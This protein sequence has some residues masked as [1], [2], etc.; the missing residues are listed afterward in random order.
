GQGRTGTKYVNWIPTYNGHEW[1]ILEVTPRAWGSPQSKLAEVVLSE[2]HNERGEPR[3]ELNE[4]ERRRIL[5]WI[6]LNVPYYG[7][8][9]TAY[10]KQRGCRQL[11]PPNLDAVLA[12]VAK[13]RC[14]ECHDGGKIPRREWVRIT[15]PEMNPFLIAP[16]ALAAGGSEKCGKAIFADRKDP[17]FQAIL[18][19]FKP[20][21]ELLKKNPR[22]D[23]PGAQASEDVNRCCQ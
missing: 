10:P 5:A 7:T 15:E 21:E 12:D 13:R 18:A 3:I 14:A 17:D 23:M 8:S 22:M 16:L 1:N 19:V 9:E 2:H 4:A 6:D 11:T 20:I